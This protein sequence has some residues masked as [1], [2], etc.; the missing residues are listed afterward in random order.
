[1]N[2]ARDE[3]IVDKLVEALLYE[4]YLLYPYRA[5]AIKNQ[6]RFNFGALLPPEFV[7]QNSGADASRLRMECLVEGTNDAQLSVTVRFLHATLRQV[8]RLIESNA[9]ATD[10]NLAED[11][12]S[13]ADAVFEPVQSLEVDGRDYPTWQESVEREVSL[14]TSLLASLTTDSYRQAISVAADRRYE[15]LHNQQ[16]ELVGRITRSSLAVTGHVIASSQ[17]I[18]PDVYK[19]CVEVVNDTPLEAHDATTREEA[20]RQA[21]LCAHVILHVADGEFV[22]LFDPSESLA[23]AAAGCNNQGVWPVLV[24]DPPDRRTML[25]SPIILYDYPQI[26]PESA[27]DLCDGTEIDEILMLRI[28]T[29]TEEEKR[30]MRGVDRRAREILERTEALPAEQFMKLHGVIRGLHPVR[31]ES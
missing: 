24:G 26:A 23:T 13:L 17:S 27:G 4:G 29:L 3:T 5:S 6:Q 16:G 28:M 1:M 10:G 15:Y 14:P 20:L 2:S 18:A 7:A 8:E 19:I 30:E 31:G 11:A 12:A 25:A 9:S 21:L 22:S